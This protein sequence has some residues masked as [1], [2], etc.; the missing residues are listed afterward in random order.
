MFEQHSMQDLDSLTTWQIGLQFAKSIWIFPKSR[1][2]V[3][4]LQRL[5]MLVCSV[6]VM[7]LVHVQTDA[8]F[9]VDTIGSMSEK[10]QENVPDG[11]SG[12]PTE[13]RGDAY[14]FAQV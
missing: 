3:T 9:D 11:M 7:L 12:S 8:R 4:Q 5:V 1:R 10:P 2:L 13:E 6:F 14:G